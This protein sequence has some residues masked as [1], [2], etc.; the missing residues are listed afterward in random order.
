MA[1]RCSDLLAREVG[2]G[3]MERGLYRRPKLLTGAATFFT[4]PL[5]GRVGVGGAGHETQFKAVGIIGD[6]GERPVVS[7][8]MKLVG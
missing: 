4:L 6:F 8:R 5:V 2:V 3:G 7:N 1:D